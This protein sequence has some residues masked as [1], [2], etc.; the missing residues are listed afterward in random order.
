[1]NVSSSTIIDALSTHCR[2][3]HTRALAFFYFDFNNKDAL[4]NAVLGSLIEQLSLQCASTPR[5]LESL[6][7]KTKQGGARQAPSQEDLMSTL[8]KIIRR[9]E[10]VYIVFDA[11]DECPQR[12][13]FLEVLGEVHDWELGTL[14]LLATS[15]EE[16]DIQKALRGL[17]SHEVSMDAS[18]VEGDIQV[19]ISRRLAEDVEFKMCSAAERAMVKSTLTQGA[20]G[21]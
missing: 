14:H 10:A 21:M 20:L 4:P 6:F 18:L 13:G 5:A 7:S 2:S 9:F 17:V 19:Y 1:M 12:H 11:L 15:R 3:D 16:H 8:K